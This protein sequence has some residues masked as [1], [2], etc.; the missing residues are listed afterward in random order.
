[1]KPKF[2]TNPE[3][4]KRIAE[5]ESVIAK[6]GGSHPQNAAPDPA[7]RA[8]IADAVAAKLAAAKASALASTTKLKAQQAVA[9]I[10]PAATLTATAF[11]Q[12]IA[13]PTMMR[14]EFQKLTQPER[15]AYIKSGGKL[16]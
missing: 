14:S 6:C 9:A 3:A 16:I 5:L 12:S 11:R 2:L 8:K 15:N 4:Q 10:A 7:S 13:G 1:M